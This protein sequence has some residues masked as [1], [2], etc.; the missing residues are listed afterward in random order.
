MA[1]L[2][3]FWKDWIQ[4]YTS[5]GGY[6]YVPKGR[7][8]SNTDTIQ[9]QLKLLE[10]FEGQPWRETQAKYQA[11][12]VAADLSKA[13]TQDDDQKGAPMAR[14][15][16]QVFST[17]GF[18]W[19]DEQEAITLTPAGEAF[20]ASQSPGDIVAAQAKRYQISNP[21]AG[22]K[23]TQSMEVHPVPFLLEVLI[24]VKTLT[25]TEYVLFCAKAKN[26]GA[27]EESI[28]RIKEWRR[29][30]PRRKAALIRT[31][32][33]INIAD[34][35]TRKRRSSIHNTVEL[36]SSYALAF[37]TA[38]G[39]IEATRK[40]REL[41]YRIPRQKMPE[42]NAIVHQSKSDGQ[43]IAFATKKDWMAFYGDPS[44]SAT[45]TAA[46]SYYT[47]TAQLDMVRQ[48]LDEW[49]DLNEQQ[50][51]QYLS[52]VVKEETVENILA[53]NI[54]L[55]EPGMSLVQRQLVTEVGR[56]DLFARDKNGTF[57]IIQLKKG[58]T[59]DEA[60]GQLSRHLGW[61]K[62]TR[63]RAANVRGI[64]VAKHISPKMWAALDGHGTPVEFLEYD[65]IMSLE[66][67]SRAPVS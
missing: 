49:V 22:G 55:I 52:M 64:I 47:D 34:P 21:M 13:T 27:I 48:V 1:T 51:R 38:S 56:I 45:K 66:K 26:F 3:R 61:C 44:K 31:L 5:H 20:I 23:D 2:P 19:I 42:A 32:N 15:L 39:V 12:L 50:K 67:P 18:A 60:Y 36:N 8:I 17:L 30:G 7:S 35:T 9:S 14:M 16:A 40:E 62:K 65:L 25:R 46:L 54:E 41:L 4:R 24:D 57:T 59:D 63:A 37:W 6:W 28:E 58:K 11:A 33:E 43:Y 29:L 10:Q 53:E